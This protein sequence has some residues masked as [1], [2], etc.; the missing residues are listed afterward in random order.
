MLSL[1][2]IANLGREIAEFHLACT[3][4]A[5]RIP[6]GSKTIKSD[7]IHLLDLLESPFAPTNFD[8]PPEAIGV[9]WR[10]THEFLERLVEL[11]YDEWPKIPVLIDWNLGNFSVDTDG[12]GASACSA[13]GT[14]TGSASNRAC[15]TSTSCRACPAARATAPGSRTARTRLVEP[16][17]LAFLDAPTARCSR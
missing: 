4:L 14:T 5:P 16:S 15:S 9:L 8:L 3:D 2:Q 1:D 11:G 17:F 13:G 10:H 12:D 7:A 6:G